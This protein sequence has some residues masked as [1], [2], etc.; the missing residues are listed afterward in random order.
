MSVGTGCCYTWINVNHK[1]DPVGQFQRFDYRK[2]PAWLD[3]KIEQRGWHKDITTS[4]ISSPQIHSLNHYFLDPALHIPYF[5]LVL[6]A[7]FAAEDRDAAIDAFAKETP[8]ALYKSLK[9]HL[10][11]ID[12]SK[13]ESF[14]EFF[15]TLQTY[16]GLMKQFAP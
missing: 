12:T 16:L 7:K 9:A 10:E 13:L 4:R 8:E 1:L 11:T 3:P 2:N 14:K 6:G 15:A 5:E